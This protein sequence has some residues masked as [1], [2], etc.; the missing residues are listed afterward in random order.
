MIEELSQIDLSTLD[1]GINHPFIAITCFDWPG[2][3]GVYLINRSARC[4]LLS[5]D[6]GAFG[7]L[8]TIFGFVEL[9]EH[10]FG[11]LKQYVVNDAW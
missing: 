11:K 3:V 6:D 8:M 4:K 10:A 1:P 5:D 7:L 9:C 2:A